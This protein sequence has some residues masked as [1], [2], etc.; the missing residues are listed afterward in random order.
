MS[1]TLSTKRIYLC[2]QRKSLDFAPEVT[3][4][5]ASC[6]I[7]LWWPEKMQVHMNN[8]L[9][10]LLMLPLLPVASLSVNMDKWKGKTTEENL[11][12][13]CLSTI[14]IYIFFVF[15]F[16]LP[17]FCFFILCSILCGYWPQSLCFI[18]K[19][20]TKKVFQKMN[21]SFIMEWFNTRAFQLNRHGFK[22]WFYYCI[23][24][25]LNLS[26]LR[27]LKLE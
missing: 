18:S 15:F 6:R 2:S 13:I 4:A 22:R 16:F 5:P 9:S 12:W 11:S 7:F 26:M 14:K 8:N 3:L 19:C 17:F 1:L 10:I 21:V 20:I 27:S 25:F 24:T 23:G